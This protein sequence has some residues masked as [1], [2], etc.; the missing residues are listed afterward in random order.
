MKY[1]QQARH[2]LFAAKEAMLRRAEQ[3]EGVYVVGYEAEPFAPSSM[4][5]GCR[6]QL[7]IVRN[8][9][10]ACWDFITKGL[11]HRGCACRWQHPSWQTSV[12]VTIK[13]M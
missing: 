8:E 5:I 13:L 7:A 6:G 12:E 3:S 9:K 4:G 1:H 10:S 2:A 11:C